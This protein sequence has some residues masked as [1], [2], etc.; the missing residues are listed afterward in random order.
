MLISKYLLQMLKCQS[1]ENSNKLDVDCLQ[2]GGGESSFAK[3]EISTQTAM[4]ETLASVRRL[5][6]PS[7]CL[8]CIHTV[9]CS[10][11]GTA[12]PRLSLFH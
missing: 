4:P 8:F 5:R 12:L 10:I 6:L 1:V 11:R 2:E 7:A 9:N 3:K